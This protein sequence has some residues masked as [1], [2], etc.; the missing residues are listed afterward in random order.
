MQSGVIPRR[1]EGLSI[2]EPRRPEGLSVDKPMRLPPVRPTEQEMAEANQLTPF[3]SFIEKAKDSTAYVVNSMAELGQDI[4][5]T[6]D[7]L[8]MMIKD[9]GYKNTLGIPLDRKTQTKS[10]LKASTYSALQDLAKIALSKGRMS[11]EWDDYG[12]DSNNINIKALIGE[13]DTKA[14]DDFYPRNKSGFLR[15]AKTLMVDPKLDA[16]LTIGGASLKKNGKGEIIL[17][18]TYD[19][20]KFLKGSASG[21]IY[22]F[23]RNYLGKEGRLSL[24]KTT[25]SKIK[26]EVNLGKLEE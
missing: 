9:V 7:A 12:V 21:G 6:P 8:A 16:A 10:D 22:G 14:A 13:G 18:D 26:W 2:D 5:G 17:T 23:V 19:A 11:I 25:D 4:T 15:L 1:P 3:E 24:E 20:E